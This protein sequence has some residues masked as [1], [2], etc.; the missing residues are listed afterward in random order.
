MI[1]DMNNVYQMS[2][3][4]GNSYAIMLV[5]MKMRTGLMLVNVLKAHK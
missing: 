1:Q 5:E 4:L 3:L 2:V